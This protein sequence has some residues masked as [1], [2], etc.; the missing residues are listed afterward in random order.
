MPTDAALAMAGRT[1]PPASTGAVVR[2]AAQRLSRAYKGKEGERRAGRC[3][4]PEEDVVRARSDTW[5]SAWER[6]V[7]H[8]EAHLP[9]PPEPVEPAFAGDPLQQ[10]TRGRG[11]PMV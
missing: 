5:F 9:P 3:H 2:R 11:A 6:D 7:D 4:H 1:L 8:P 10:V